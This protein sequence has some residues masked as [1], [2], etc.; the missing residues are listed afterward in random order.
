MKIKPMRKILIVIITLLI[1]MLVLP[2][3]I[4]KLA[5]SDAGMALCFILF[6][7]V[8][9]FTILALSIM[10][11]TE[12]RKLW[13][14]PVAG[15]V[16]FPLFF[17]VAVQEVVIELFVYSIFYAIAGILAMLGTHFGIKIINKRKIAKQERMDR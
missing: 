5:P 3:L 8:D 12:L 13:W 10:A 9:P 17:G 15:A 1:I 6:F 2:V 16:A 7:V 4:V 11:G 14:V